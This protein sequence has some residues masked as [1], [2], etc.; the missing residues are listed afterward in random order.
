MSFNLSPTAWVALNST[1]YRG[2]QAEIN[3]TL[4]ANLQDNSRLGATLSLPVGRRS[5]IKVSA[6]TGV[7][8]S[9]GGDFNSIGMSWQTVVF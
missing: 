9:F 6:S 1:Y 7:T 8:T 4:K 5:S 3:G 2:G